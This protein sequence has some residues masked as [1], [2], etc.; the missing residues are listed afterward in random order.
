MHPIKLVA[1]SVNGLVLLSGAVAVITPT[2]TAAQGS[3]VTDVNVVNTVKLRDVDNPARL[4]YQDTAGGAFEL[5][6]FR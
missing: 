1:I 6:L 5:L 3:P 2:P 4:A